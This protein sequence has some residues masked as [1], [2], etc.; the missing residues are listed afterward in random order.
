MTKKIGRAEANLHIENRAKISKIITL[1][2][3]LTIQVLYSLKKVQTTLSHYRIHQSRKALEKLLKNKAKSL[4][5]LFIQGP[6]KTRTSMIKL[7]V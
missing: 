4:R 2:K 5:V 6:W 1:R 3:Y 7:T